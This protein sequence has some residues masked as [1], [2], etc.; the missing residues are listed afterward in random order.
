MNTPA[1]NAFTNFF[2]KTSLEVKQAG[3]ATLPVHYPALEETI[4]ASKPE[5]KIVLASEVKKEQLNA[6][7]AKHITSNASS[8]QANNKNKQKFSKR[9]SI[10]ANHEVIPVLCELTGV[11]TAL[12]VP[13]IPIGK[14]NPQGKGNYND[15]IVLTYISPY[16]IYENARTFAQ[17]GA[18]YLKQLDTQILAAIAIT[19]ADNYELFVYSPTDSGVQKNAVLRTVDKDTLIDS[20]ILVEEMINTGNYS[21]LPK[22]S[23]RIDS[24]IVQDGIAVRMRNWLK[25]VVER[26]YE[27][28]TQTYDE[29]MTLNKLD[30][31]PTIAKA[32]REKLALHK[33][34]REFKAEAKLSINALYKEQKISGKLKLFLT[35][36]ITGQNIS[37]AAPEMIALLCKKLYD[38]NTGEAMELSDN[39]DYFYNKLQ[40]E[41]NEFDQ[42]ME[43]KFANLP[44]GKYIDDSS[45]ED[46][47]FA[48]SSGSSKPKAELPDFDI[49]SKQTK[50]ERSVLIAGTQ[51]VEKKLSFVEQLKAKRA[52]AE[53][54]KQQNGE[55]NE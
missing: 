46:D 44:T 50:Q 1:N 9:L 26:I 11:V 15:P 31:K 39:I 55:E 45:N 6:R 7:L 47:E 19:L 33:E 25:L 40:D 2:N 48:T 27:P 8:N 53:L 23:I 34:F 30:N 51:V 28:D 35:T 17:A 32:R 12:M 49:P 13:A 5:I 41:D 10:S 43:V 3:E 21:F 20:I 38:I 42:P 18:K 36:V 24:E 52:A 29:A 4:E 22:L 14:A 54:A 37:T 16:G